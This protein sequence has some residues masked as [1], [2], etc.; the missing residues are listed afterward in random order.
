[1]NS[2]SLTVDLP[3]EDTI[4]KRVLGEFVRIF[5]YIMSLL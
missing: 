1:V 3:N 2:I 4:M 5:L